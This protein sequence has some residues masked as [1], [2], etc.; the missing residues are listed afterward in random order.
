MPTITFR[1]L[2]NRVRTVGGD[3]WFHPDGPPSKDWVWIVGKKQGPFPYAKGPIHPIRKRPDDQVI[4]KTQ[5]VKILKK[6][7]FDAAEQ[8]QFWNVRE[9][10]AA[11]DQ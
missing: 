3:V 9:H 11:N 6:I 5:V 7:G 1:N 10:R 4:P 2:L 8:A